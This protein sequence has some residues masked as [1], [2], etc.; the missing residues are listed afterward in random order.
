MY[1]KVCECWQT[2]CFKCRL[3]PAIIQRNSGKR[4]KQTALVPERAI[5]ALTAGTV[6]DMFSEKPYRFSVLRGRLLVYHHGSI[7]PIDDRSVNE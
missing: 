3:K 1:R 4:L 6:W 2:R 5:Q 7:V